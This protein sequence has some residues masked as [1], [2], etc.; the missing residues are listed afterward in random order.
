MKKRTLFSMIV[1]VAVCIMLS[2]PAF[3]ADCPPELQAIGINFCGE[4]PTLDAITMPATAEYYPGLEPPCNMIADMT[5]IWFETTPQTMASLIPPDVAYIPPVVSLRN[6]WGVPEEAFPAFCE[7][8]LGGTPNACGECDL[9]PFGDKLMM[10]L[11]LLDYEDTSCYGPYR[12]VILLMPVITT[13]P[14]PEVLSCSDD[15]VFNEYGLS[16]ATDWQYHYGLTI[17]GL[18]SYHVGLYV[19]YLWL[20]SDGPIAAGRETWGYPKKMADISF[21]DA[22]GRR[23]WEVKRSLSPASPIFGHVGG[24]HLSIL[25]NDTVV[26]PIITAWVEPDTNNPRHP[27]EVKFPP[28]YV[29]KIIPSVEGDKSVINELNLVPLDPQSGNGTAGYAPFVTFGPAHL[30]LIGGP[31]DPINQIDVVAVYGGYQFRYDFYLSAGR[32]LIDYIE[33]REEGKKKD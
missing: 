26:E 14:K 16:V 33:D 31:D 29:N 3:G 8:T 19:P 20:S 10:T 13:D 11:A 2:T 6:I 9:K 30:E 15:P 18:S 1:A 7:T 28:L 22:D 24:D 25:H 23:T 32:T 12:E 4:A 27:D 17:P 21:T 5:L